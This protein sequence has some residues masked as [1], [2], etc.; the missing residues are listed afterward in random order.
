MH[1]DTDK[2]VEIFSDTSGGPNVLRARGSAVAKA[3]RAGESGSATYDC[4]SVRKDLRAMIAEGHSLGMELPLAERT[5]RVY[6]EAS[7]AGWGNRDCTELPAYW[8]G[9]KP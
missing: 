6:D 2:L 4:D 9:R 5:L 7:G 8:V 1:L 3:L